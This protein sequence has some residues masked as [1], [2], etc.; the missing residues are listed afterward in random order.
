MVGALGVDLVALEFKV[1]RRDAQQR[2]A[3]ALVR[4]RS[5]MPGQS[6]Y[7]K[8]VHEVGV[9]WGVLA[10]VRREERGE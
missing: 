7:R 1:R 6:G 10:R 9:A 2:Y 8:A 5:L 4:K 3:D